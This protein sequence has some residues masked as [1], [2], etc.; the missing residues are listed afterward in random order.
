[1]AARGYRHSWIGASGPRWPIAMVTGLTLNVIATIAPV[2]DV[3]T[4][5]TLSDHVRAAYP[6]WGPSLVDADRNA[7][8]IYL[9]VTGVLGIISWLCVIRAVVAGKRWAPIAA[10]SAF[11]VGAILALTN[12]TL[13][14]GHYHVILP[15]GYGVLT[16]LPS[17]A[18]LVAVVS[19]W[20][21]P[22]DR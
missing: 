12:L 13:G 21:R 4:V 11:A 18:G 14:G 16:L 17:L 3:A 20:R 15:T 5:D 1:M 22:A 9:V 2:V 19:L 7:M 10:T 6:A 8:L